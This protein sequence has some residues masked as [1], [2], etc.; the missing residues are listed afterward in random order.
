[1]DTQDHRFLLDRLANA[2]LGPVPLY[3]SFPTTITAQSL[4]DL[5]KTCSSLTSSSLL[6]LPTWEPVR[7]YNLLLFYLV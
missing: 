3:R 2:H 5:L 6:H 1:M 7:H 4:P